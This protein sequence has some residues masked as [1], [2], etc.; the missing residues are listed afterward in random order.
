MRAAPRHLLSRRT[1]LMGGAALPALLLGRADA[2]P[3]RGLPAMTVYRDPGCGC[4]G[5]WAGM[6]RRAGFPVTMVDSA[7]MPGLKRRLGVPGQ[8]SACHTAVVGGYVIEG[9]VP[10]DRVAGLVARRPR[11]I[12]GLAVPGMPLGSPGMEAPGG[13]RESF[14][15][16][17]FDAA[18]R[19]VALR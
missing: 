19:V 12:R 4:C 8:L 17:A 18:G 1:L 3:P 7:D 16:F 11:G 15:V 6:A 2:A 5:N 13:A 10:F 14:Q 9:H